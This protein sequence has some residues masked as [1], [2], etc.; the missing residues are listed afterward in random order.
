MDECPQSRPSSPF[1]V[2][3]DPEPAVQPD[4]DSEWV[5]YVAWLDRESAAGRDPEPVIWARERDE[6]ES[7]WPT[8][9]SFDQGEEADV[10][11]PGALL[12]GS[13]TRRCA[14]LAVS[15]TAS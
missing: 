10:L 6:A 2:P 12:L 1:A 14:I 5:E 4:P 11:P 13:P 9:P 15:R 3:P 7:P 8:L